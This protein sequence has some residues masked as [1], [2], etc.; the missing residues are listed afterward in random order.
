MN[1]MTLRATVHGAWRR[2]GPSSGF[3]ATALVLL[4]LVAG[5]FPTPVHAADDA[6]TYALT[7]WAAE[8]GASPGDVFAITQDPGG[9]LWLG[10]Q[11]GLV[12][13][14]GL[15][16]VPWTDAAG[17][18]VS[19]P[20]LALVTARD[21]SLWAGGSGSIYR[22]RGHA[23][24]RF[25][26]AEGFRGSVTTLLEDRQ[27]VVWAGS[28]FGLFRLDNVKAR[29]VVLDP[30]SGFPGAEVFSLHEDQSGRLYVGSAAGVWVK[31]KDTFELADGSQL[32]VQ[33]FAEDDAGAIWV[34]HSDD[35]VKRLDGRPTGAFSPEIRR[36][37]SGWRLLHD[38]RGQIWVAALGG[39]LLRVDHA[40]K[41]TAVIR[42]IEYGHR[43]SGSSRSLFEDHEGNIWVGLRG[44]LLRLSEAVFR[45][46][47]PLEGV[48]QDGVRT[49]AVSSDGS[50]WVATSHDINRF[51][52]G[53]R[54]VYPLPQTFA[55]HDDH[56]G[57][58]WA[59]TSHGL[60]RL[61][62]ERF[63]KIPIPA[64]IT[65]GRV[66]A[67][68]IDGSGSVWLCSQLRGVMV[69]NGTSLT[70]FEK[71]PDLGGRTCSTVYEDRRGRVWV[72]LGGGGA[73]VYDGG[74]FQMIGE[75]EGLTRGSV[76]A[77]TEDRSGAVWLGTPS[78]I[79][80]YKNG[81]L[82]SLTSTNAPIAD[83]VPSIVEDDE[84]YMW[85][86]MKAG[87]AALRIHPRELDK[88][89]TNPSA[90]IEYA[91]FDESD[92][93]PQGALSWQFGTTGVRGGD[94]RLWFAAGLGL[95][96]INPASTR[97]PLRRVP[98]PQ[99]EAA[100]AD[101]RPV[102]LSRGLSLPAQTSTLRIEYGALSLSA[103]SKLRFRYMLEGLHDDWLQAGAARAAVLNDLP[104][105]DYRFRV[106]ATYEGQ[107]TEAATWDFSVAPPFY[108]TPRFLMLTLLAIASLV[109]AA[110]WLRIRAVRQQYAMVFAERARLSREIH[111]TL[112]QGLAALGVELE[113][114]ASQVAPSDGETRDGL[115]RLRRQ[116][117][118]SLREA[119]ES[120]LDLRR[121]PMK[122]GGLIQS[123]TD[124]AENTSRR[125]VQA[126]FTADGR[127]ERSP[128][129]EVDVQLLRIAQE[130]VS[131]ALKHGHATHLHLALRSDADNIVLTVE[132]NGQGFA[133]EER[134]SSPGRGEHLG[135]LSMRERA[136]RIR[137]RLAI[138]SAPGR[139]TTIQATVPIPSE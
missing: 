47:T 101:G 95:A 44:G 21:G 33:S 1:Q 25:G 128:D 48:T 111:D 137:G 40:G 57:S 16:F 114:L 35:A 56:R 65:W 123:L 68:A 127:L 39:G 121:H 31:G 108:R 118:H 104:A 42:R 29:W 58:M 87:S 63:V 81:R 75:R 85:V 64:P 71:H 94:G 91:I 37:A 106:S 129:D 12:R 15:H 59:S 117:G 88:V 126:D 60:W 36:P 131:N 27:G 122:S 96:T 107:W 3:G 6:P 103:A 100:S 130:A 22:V 9:Y 11:A 77:V 124:L 74:S 78:G 84:G 67:I 116:V 119:R 30:S 110:W 66:F 14:D 26:E 69:W 46:D 89:A 28:R 54:T 23:V 19:G 99:I 112:L 5:S 51:S 138:V 102:D 32:N 86:G 115:R 135:L 97:P 82:V 90:P 136:E 62:G 139:G 4:T 8:T 17:A 92:G 24:Q 76:L 53:G 72:G 105:G 52:S 41:P 7:V 80:R 132:D 50:V 45:T 10:T 79:N 20:V 133:A 120:I 49:L 98:V 83:V 2:P 38:R 73:A 18:P 113:A 13:F 43:T 70:T 109:A 55:L 34:G 93:F 61:D 125:G 134:Q